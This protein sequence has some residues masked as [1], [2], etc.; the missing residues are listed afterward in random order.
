[1]AKTYELVRKIAVLGGHEGGT[2]KEL[3]IVRWGFMPPQI[4]IRRWKEGEPSKGITLNNAES[5]K[6]LDALHQEL[7]DVNTGTACPEV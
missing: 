5:R 2:T 7:T 4:D 3:N 1:M 6:L